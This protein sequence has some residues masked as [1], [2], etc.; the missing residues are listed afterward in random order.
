MKDDDATRVNDAAAA[1]GPRPSIGRRSAPPSGIVPPLHRA[2]FMGAIFSM[3][4]LLSWAAD[5]H[6]DND[7]NNNGGGGGGGTAVGGALCAQTSD[8]GHLRVIS[9]RMVVLLD[10]IDADVVILTSM[11]TE[12]E[13]SN[14]IARAMP[15]TTTT[16][17]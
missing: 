10:H 5:E 13:Q 17:L 11:T 14:N 16:T 2:S 4:V 7:N 9:L 3:C 6:D 1:T 12:G 15:P 8:G